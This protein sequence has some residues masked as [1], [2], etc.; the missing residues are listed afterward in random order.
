M[1]APTDE[2]RSVRPF[3]W[4]GLVTLAL[5]I[6]VSVTTEF[7]PTG[8]LPEMASEY[9]VS[10]SQVGLLVTIFAATVVLATTPLSI[11]TRGYSRKGLVVVVL[12]IIAVGALGAAVAPTY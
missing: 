2:N 7:L 11:L 6:F 9:H 5:A 12:L 10:L 4:L 1:A 3:P 8:L